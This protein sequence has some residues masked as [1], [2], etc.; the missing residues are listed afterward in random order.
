MAHIGKFYR[1][2]FRRDLGLNTFPGNVSSWPQTYRLLLSGFQG[3]LGPTLEG[4]LFDVD[5]Q[6]DATNGEIVYET[7]GFAAGSF[8][9]HVK[10]RCFIVP[11]PQRYRYDF[12]VR[13]ATMG[14][15]YGALFNVPSQSSY[16]EINCS[17]FPTNGAE[18]KSTPELFGGVVGTRSIY[19]AKSWNFP[20]L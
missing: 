7:D 8:F 1:L 11:N 5:I 3:T 12:S 20:P 16:G 19:R 15:L 14:I 10:V 18:Y 13:S 17:F 9:L 4:R 2:A 6:V